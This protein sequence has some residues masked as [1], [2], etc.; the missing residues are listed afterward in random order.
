MD[1]GTQRWTRR[2]MQEKTENQSWDQPR[3]GEAVGARGRVITRR[4]RSSLLFDIYSIVSP[5][6]TWAP[7]AFQTPSCQS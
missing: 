1:D 5:A 6:T 3:A 7:P 2:L 4:A